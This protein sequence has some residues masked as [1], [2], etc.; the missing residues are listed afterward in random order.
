MP[1]VV[2]IRIDGLGGFI[3][4]LAAVCPGAASAG[5]IE[6]RSTS[7]GVGNAA[8]GERYQSDGRH[9]YLVVKD[10]ADAKRFLCA[11]HDRAWL[12]ALVGY[13]I[14]KAGQL[15]DRSII[16]RMVCAPERFVFEAAPDLES[17]LEQRPRPATVHDGAPLDTLAACPDLSA[18]EVGELQRLKAAAAIALKHEAATANAAFVEEQVGNAVERG[19]DPARARAAAEASSRGVLRPPRRARLRRRGDRDEDRRRRARR[20][21]AV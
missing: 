8:T 15:L 21:S 9:L 5:Y 1:D 13:W 4:A 12:L 18:H 14:G 6:R 2:R 16:D 19:V 3:G 10:G 20:P 11:L 7:A 17:P